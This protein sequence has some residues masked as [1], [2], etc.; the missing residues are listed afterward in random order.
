MA[1]N[2]ESQKREAAKLPGERL[3]DL[4]SQ[5]L[6]SPVAV[7]R[8]EAIAI[9]NAGIGGRPDL[10]PGKEYVRRVKRMWRGLLPRD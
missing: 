3:K 9:V 2:D 7:T 10:P 4:L 1:S 6:G 8:E 5:P